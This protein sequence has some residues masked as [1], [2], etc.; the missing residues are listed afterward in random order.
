[1]KLGKFGLMKEQLKQMNKKGVKV[2]IASCGKVLID[3]LPFSFSVASAGEASQKGI[4]VSFSG[5]PVEDGRLVLSTIEMRYTRNGRAH[6]ET[7]KLARIVKRD[8]KHIYQAKFTSVVLEEARPMKKKA[9]SDMFLA[10]ISSSYS[11]RLIPSYKQDEEAEVML[12]V[13]PLAD[14]LGGLAVEWRSC[15]SDKE[16]F[17]HNPDALKP[18]SRS[19]GFFMRHR[20]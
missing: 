10:D 15:T 20:R 2:S 6:S 19:K 1:M 12:T 4:V 9:D 5:E 3:E 16:W 8:G 17:E 7:K 14:P 18:V 13:Y 11:F